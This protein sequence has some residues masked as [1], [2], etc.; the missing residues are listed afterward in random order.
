LLC[1]G[2]Y[3]QIKKPFVLKSAGCSEVPTGVVAYEPAIRLLE[4]AGPSGIDSAPI[5]IV[6]KSFK[7][8]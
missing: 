7:M 4:D 1:A 5:F 3:P 6:A 2:I 8:P